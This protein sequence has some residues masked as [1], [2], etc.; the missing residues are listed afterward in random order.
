VGLEEPDGEEK[1]PVAGAFQQ[2]ERHWHDVV[3]VAGA[4]LDHF[5]V[6]DDIGLL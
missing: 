2:V 4:D 5:V 3:S 1:G 6:T